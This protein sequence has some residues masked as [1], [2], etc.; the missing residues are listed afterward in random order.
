MTAPQEDKS[1]P[2]PKKK[3]VIFLHHN[4]LAKPINQVI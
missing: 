1:T 3:S 2:G 4:L